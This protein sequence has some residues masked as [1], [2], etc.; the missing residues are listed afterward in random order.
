MQQNLSLDAYSQTFALLTAFAAAHQ[1][2][3]Q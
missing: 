1:I 2:V 3:F